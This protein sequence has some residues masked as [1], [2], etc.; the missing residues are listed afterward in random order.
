MNVWFELAPSATF[1]LEGLVVSTDRDS[2]NG[3]YCHRLQFVDISD[4][5][6]ESIAAYILEARRDALTSHSKGEPVNA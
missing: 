6:Q 4:G 3:K 1:E 5:D 2:S